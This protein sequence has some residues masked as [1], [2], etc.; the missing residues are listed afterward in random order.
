M[1]SAD[2]GIGR[3][4]SQTTP[5]RSRS[6]STRQSAHD[7]GPGPAE[8]GQDSE[9][10][11]AGLGRAASSCVRMARCP[12]SSP[13]PACATGS[14]P[15]T[16]DDVVS[17]PYDVISEAERVALEARQ[18]VQLGPGR[19]APRRPALR[20]LPGGRRPARAW[21]AERDPRAGQPGPPSTATG[22]GSRTRPAQP[23]ETVGV[24]GALGAGT[25]RR[26]RHPAPRADHA[27]AEERPPRPAAG[28]PGQPLADLG[29]VAR[30][31]AGRLIRRRPARPACTDDDG[32]A[33]EIWPI[34]DP[35]AV[36][37]IARRRARRRSSSPTATTATRR[38]CLPAGAAGGDRRPAGRR[39]PVMALDRRAGPRAALGAGHSPAD[40]RPARRFDL[41]GAFAEPTSTWS[42]P[43]GPDPT[44]GEPH[45]GSGRHAVVT[46]QGTW[47]AR[48]R[49]ADR[50]GRGD[51]DA[52]RLDR[53][54]AAL[55]RPRS[56]LPARLGPGRRGRG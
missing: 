25:R 21:R 45:G 14:V 16:L 40:R 26:R 44:I 29:A 35:A 34:T 7:R 51:L 42:R 52:S 6:Q 46:R 13:F 43:T 55:A 11:L 15:V 37:A 27:Q 30:H 4:D 24:I 12:A 32:V 39:R 50:R 33:H 10:Q 31:R 3:P 18:P 19:T 48:P 56:R 22:C 2:P 1:A 36:A 53:V 8:L 20:P 23:P 28:H 41:L 5:S 17:P 47:L 54:L 49:P 9:G 38:R